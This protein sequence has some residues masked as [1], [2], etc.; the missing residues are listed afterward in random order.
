MRHLLISFILLSLTACDRSSLTEFTVRGETM[1]ST[2]SIIY[3]DS[4]GRDLGTALDSMLVEFNA[5]F[6]TY[7]TSSVISA[8][9][10]S[11]TGIALIGEQLEWFRRL[12]AVSDEVHAIHNGAFNPAIGPLVQYWGFYNK[13]ESLEAEPPQDAIDSL[14]VI[15][16]YELVHLDQQFLVKDDPAVRLD[17]N[18]IAPGFAADLLGEFLEANGIQRYMVEI[19]GEIR[20]RGLNSRN[21]GWTV[22]IRKPEEL[23]A[24]LVSTITLN[25]LSLATSGNYNKYVVVDGRKMGHTIDPHTGRPAVNELLSATL[26]TRNCMHADALATVCMVGGFEQAKELILRQESLE[27]Y[28]IYSDEAG[29]MATWISPGMEDLIREVQ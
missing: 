10:A 3:L 8:F 6:S 15:S 23:S 26:I 20:A 12:F 11:D 9:N 22:G 25:D 14:L 27:G 18:A 16:R 1:G 5:V 17:V 28:L 7:D 2:Y 29:K 13:Q 24:Q 4:A 21:T 19:G